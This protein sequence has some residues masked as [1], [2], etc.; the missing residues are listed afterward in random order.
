MSAG[1]VGVAVPPF[2][3]MGIVCHLSAST[4]GDSAEITSWHLARGFSSGGYHG[5]ILNGRPKAH[6]RYAVDLDGTLQLGRAVTVQGAHCLEGG[7]NPLTLGICCIG[8]PGQPLA[9]AQRAPAGFTRRAYLT[10]RQLDTLI[11]HLAHICRERGWDP[12]GTF[13]HPKTGTLIPVIT[14]HSD[15]DPAKPFCASLNLFALRAAVAERLHD[16][17]DEAFVTPLLMGVPPQTGG[18]AVP[19]IPRP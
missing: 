15:H 5:V 12:A 18:I 2:H 9:E 13:R 4:W 11:L 7:M 6:S 14:Q 1:T 17:A 16:V 10:A 3:P 19:G 8:Q